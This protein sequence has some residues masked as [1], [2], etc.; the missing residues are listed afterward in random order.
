MKNIITDYGA[1]PGQDCTAAFQAAANDGGAVSVPLEALPYYVIDT[2]VITK[3]FRLMGDLMGQTAIASRVS[4][5]LDVFTF[6]PAPGTVMSGS[7]LEHLYIYGSGRYPVYIDLSAAGAWMSDA[8]FSRL[9]LEPTTAGVDAAFC[10]NN[11]TNRDGFFTSVIEKSTFVGGIKLIRCGDSV[12]LLDSKTTGPNLGLNASFVPGA[13]RMA[14]MRNNITNTAGGILLIGAEQAY[15]LGNQMEQT[16][17]QT[18]TYSGQ[19]MLAGCRN[20]GIRANNINNHG[21]IYAGIAIESY[22]DPVSG[23]AAGTANTIISE[24]T[25]TTAGASVHLA[26]GRNCPGGAALGKTNPFYGSPQGPGFAVTD[27]DASSSLLQISC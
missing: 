13:A 26:M 20:C 11:P 17:P 19:I 5:N 12:S 21:N 23:A 3:P 9:Y 4:P 25:M 27:I 6:R 15:I 1:V 24:N 18:G 10:M 22:T 2:V 14:I 7:G 8:N 16:Q